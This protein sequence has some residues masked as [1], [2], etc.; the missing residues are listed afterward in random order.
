MEMNREQIEIALKSCLDNEYCATC[1][2]TEYCDGIESLFEIAL[3]LI[4]KYA[5]ENERYKRFY[6]DKEYD[7]IEAEIRADTARKMIDRFRKEFLP[8][9][10]YTCAEIDAKF[11][12]LQRELLGEVQ[13]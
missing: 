1:T 5:D 2:A 11:H 3:A 7:K 13:R 10:A 8:H 4:S 12:K 9:T 6:I